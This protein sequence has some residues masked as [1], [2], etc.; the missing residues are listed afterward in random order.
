[1]KK[2]KIKIRFNLGRGCNYKK[3][4]IEY[5]H[6]DIKYIDPKETQ[7]HMVHCT[8]KNRKKTAERIFKGENKTVCA[9]IE[10]DAL[11]F[12]TKGISLDFQILSYNP[13]KAPYWQLKNKNVDNHYFNSI[14]SLGKNLYTEL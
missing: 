3:W 4:K 12:G 10:C 6:G 5:P 7:L 2:E 8:L 13:R 14:T 11:V 9:W 1:M